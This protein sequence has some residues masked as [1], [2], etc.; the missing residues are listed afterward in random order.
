MDPNAYRLPSALLALPA[1]LA[2]ACVFD[3]PPGSDEA[4]EPPEPEAAAEIHT[5]QMT[6]RLAIEGGAVI[7]FDLAGG[8]EISRQGAWDP[9]AYMPTAVA[10][11]PLVLGAGVVEHADDLRDLETWF[12]EIES[13]HE[14]CEALDDA[15]CQAVWQ[16]ADL[17]RSAV[18]T[19][20]LADGTEVAT[21]KLVN[22]W[23]QS[24]PIAHELT[25]VI[26][27]RLV[28]EVT[29]F[30]FG[31]SSRVQALFGGEPVPVVFPEPPARGGGTT[32]V[33]DWHDNIGRFAGAYHGPDAVLARLDG[34]EARAEAAFEAE[35][36]RAAEVNVRY[37]ANV[38]HR[39]KIEIEGVI[40]GG[41]KSVSGLD[42]ETEVVEYRDGYGVVQKRP[43]R[44]KFGNITLERGVTDGHGLLDGY[45]AA[46]RGA[47]EHQ[48]GSIII[49]DQAGETEV[50]RFILEG[51]DFVRWKAPELNAHS[52][53]HAVE[54]L[55][56][57]VE[58]VE[59]G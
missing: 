31:T 43:G 20:L 45:T 18:L 11:S 2:T 37:G 36:G 25:H 6:F 46:I 57:A 55:E 48:S 50:A 59:R 47:S 58:R 52:D 28:A 14:M 21:W 15:T 23:P 27:Q 38:P 56:L 26:Q 30:S 44:P 54:E 33:D 34:L 1:M 8:L 12:E 40:Q 4:C 10:F 13:F 35:T 9:E 7:D 51:L 16:R 19:A 24:Q 41:F 39:F 49:L 17:T 53:S 32:A 29:E 5:E 3:L 22:A 42:S